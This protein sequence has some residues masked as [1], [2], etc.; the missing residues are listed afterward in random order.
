MASH[1]SLGIPCYLA[2][3]GATLLMLVDTE[4]GKT[5]AIFSSTNQAENFLATR[6]D[7]DEF[8]ILEFTGLEMLLP[9][10]EETKQHAELVAIDPQE[11]VLDRELVWP[12]ESVMTYLEEKYGKDV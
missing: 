5:V 7:G 9:I 6:T 4:G 1:L 3:R 8:S 10:L 12:I 2:I 11:A